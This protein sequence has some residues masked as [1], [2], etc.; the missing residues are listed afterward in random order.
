MHEVCCAVSNRNVNFYITNIS[1]S[2]VKRVATILANNLSFDSENTKPKVIS[3]TKVEEHGSPLFEY[4]GR[5][6]L[7]IQDFDEQMNYRQSLMNEGI[8]TAAV[9]SFGKDKNTKIYKFKVLK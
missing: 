4:L 9:H 1:D 8:L 7:Q 2:I 6:I 5:E 3:I